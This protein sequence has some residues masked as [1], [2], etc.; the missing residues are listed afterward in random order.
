MAWCVFFRAAA[1]AA[2]A[3]R[4]QLPSRDLL[5]PCVRPIDMA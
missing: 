3:V 5:R 2:S 1:A 4:L